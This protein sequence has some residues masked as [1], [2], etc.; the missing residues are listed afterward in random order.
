[1]PEVSEKTPVFRNI[2]VKNLVSRNARRAMFFN[3]LPEMNIKNII[4]EKTSISA[5]YGAELS[6]SDGVEFRDVEIYPTE[7]SALKL[8]NVR[9]MVLRDA[10]NS[11]NSKAIVEISGSSTKSIVLPESTKIK[12]DGVSEKV[13]SF[14]K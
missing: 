13:V 10:V 9:N 14:I 11:D 2:F 4:V 3:G 7:G 5:R 12:L 1:M 8:N 6:E